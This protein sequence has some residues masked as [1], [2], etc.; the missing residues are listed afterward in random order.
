MHTESP[1][2]E[3]GWLVYNHVDAEAGKGTSLIRR[4]GPK[5]AAHESEMSPSPLVSDYGY[6]N[7]GRMQSRNEDLHLTPDVA[8]SFRLQDVHGRGMIWL[9]A[10]DGRDEFMVQIDPAE[11]KFTVRKNRGTRPIG[12]GDLPGPLRG[13]T[14]EVSLIDRQFL[15]A[16]GSKTIFTSDIDTGDIDTPGEPP[17][18]GATAG[19]RRAGPGRGGRPSS[20]LPRD[21]LWRSAG[22]GRRP[23]PSYAVGP[24]EYFVLGDNNPISED[25][26]TWGTYASQDPMVSHK[27]LA[28]KPFMVLYPACD[29]SLAGWHIQVPDLTR[30]RY[31]R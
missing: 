9:Q 27:S 12:A 28:G 26:R 23:A 19:D 4:N 1:N 22:L 11:R 25:S 18:T 24:E 3:I 8:M 7:C 21:I 14:F 13:E 29:L 17:L 5:G 2:D 30:I 16:I 15:L 6:Y 10:S 20:R 31:I